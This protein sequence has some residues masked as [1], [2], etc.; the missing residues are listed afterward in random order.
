MKNI[1]KIV[2][3]SLLCT[4]GF[5]AV[6]QKSVWREATSVYGS[7]ADRYL[8]LALPLRVKGDGKIFPLV[9]DSQA[10]YV[11]EAQ[12]SVTVDDGAGKKSYDVEFAVRRSELNVRGVVKNI[13]V[14]IARKDVYDIV[15][16]LKDGE[17]SVE[18]HNYFKSIP[19]NTA[20]R[21]F[22]GF[23]GSKRFGVFERAG[24]VGAGEYVGLKIVDGK[25]EYIEID[26]SPFTDLKAKPFESGDRSLKSRTSSLDYAAGEW[27][28]ISELRIWNIFHYGIE[29]PKERRLTGFLKIE[30][31]VKPLPEPIRFGNL[32]L[33]FSNVWYGVDYRLSAEE[34]KAAII[35]SDRSLVPK[36]SHFVF[37]KRSEN[38]SV[39]LDIEIEVKSIEF[40]RVME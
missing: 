21:I 15:Y 17:R 23:Y 24:S 11:K 31:Y 3:I 6:Q 28:L 2:L 32:D 29:K 40:D 5:S 25:R 30:F 27:D 16:R 7:N 38:E 35:A 9:T 4:P 12:Y 18:Y 39:G 13:I 33:P 1:L 8:Y 22:P 14:D 19:D 36:R 10:Y 20:V 26:P 34:A 37:K